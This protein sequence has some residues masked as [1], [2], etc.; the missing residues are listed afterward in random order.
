VKRVVRRNEIQARTGLKLRA[1]CYSYTAHQLNRG[2][3]STDP[4][5]HHQSPCLRWPK[6]PFYHSGQELHPWG[7]LVHGFV[8]KR[9]EDPNSGHRAKPGIFVGHADSTPGYLVYHEDTDTVVTYGYVDVF[10][11]NFPCK[12]RMMS[13]ED[14][15]TLV[16]GDW[17]R[18]SDYRPGDVKDGPFSEFVTG[19]QLEVLLPQTMYPSFSGQWKAV[20]QRP[21]TLGSKAVCMRMVFTGY[22]GNRNELSLK[23]RE[24]LTPESDL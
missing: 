10:P 3:S 13:G 22:S 7:C 18:W 4:S 14:P 23:D 9:S 24:C 1:L 19:K 2:P 12:E 17:R 16:S 11:R 15:A 21:I 20:C 8:G 6:A 5:G